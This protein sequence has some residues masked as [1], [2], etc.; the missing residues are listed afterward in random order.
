MRNFAKGLCCVSALGLVAAAYADKP[1]LRSLDN[2]MKVQPLRVAPCAKIDGQVVRTGPWQ[3]Y[4]DATRGPACTHTLVFDCF[5]VDATG[6]PYNAD[7]RCGL[8]APSSRWYFGPSYTNPFSIN[9][10][11]A[12]AGGGQD[13]SRIDY[14]WYQSGNHNYATA[15][16]S[17]DNFDDSCAGPAS[18]GSLGGVIA[19][20]GF[21]NGGG[22]YFFTN[23]EL[24]G[25]GIP[26][27]I[28]S[29]LSGAYD[30]VH[31]SYDSADPNT[32][33]VS[34]TVQMMLWGADMAA[35]DIPGSQGPIQWDDDAPPSTS[36][37]VG[38][39]TAPDECYSYAFGICPDP[40]GN[41]LAFYVEGGASCAADANG[42]SVT[43][44]DDFSVLV[45]QWN[46][47]GP[48]ADFNGDNIVNFD[49]FT[50]MVND[51]NCGV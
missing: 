7:A 28:A 12:D 19:D 18:S 24:C 5:E 3:A 51:W 45:N 14:A 15:I 26:V 38:P 43:N 11:T 32:L 25:T 21:L 39:H 35:N 13:M 6:F 34:P 27:G 10:Y 41:T 31:L 2:A 37:P 1:A 16:F 40:L 20:F 4:G 29:D 48:D 49:D 17:E 33:L 44:F 23:L 8:P 50:I 30:V 46:T 42:D 22:G 47:A 36:V 9:D